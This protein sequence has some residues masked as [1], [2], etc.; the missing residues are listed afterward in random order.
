MAVKSV[1]T[2]ACKNATNNSRHVIK[3]SSPIAG[4]KEPAPAATCIFPTIKIIS[5]RQI[6]TMCPDSIL[7]NKRMASTHTLIIKLTTSSGKISGT[8]HA[9]VPDGTKPFKN[10]MGPWNLR[11]LNK[12]NPPEQSANAAV[13]EMLEVAVF[14]SGIARRMITLPGRKF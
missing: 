13:T 9:G 6:S 1:N 2:Y 11:P 8:S 7:A 5:K 3:I 14:I 12:I 4:I 10:P